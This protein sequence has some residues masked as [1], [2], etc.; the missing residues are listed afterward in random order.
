M[1]KKSFAIIGLGRFGSSVALTL[2]DS[3][4]EVLALDSNEELV[5]KYSD[6]FTHVIAADTTDEN[7]LKSLGMRNFDVVIV[8]IGHDVQASLLTTLL[9]KEIGVE[10]IV[11]KA[12]NLLHGK[13]LE[14]IGANRVV[15]PERD[16][17]QRL[18]HNLISTNVLEYIEL[19]PNFG[20]IEAAVPT[21]LVGQTL[22]QSDLRAKFGIN[23]VALKRKGQIIVSPM[24]TELFELGDILVIIG[25]SLGIQQ[26]EKMRT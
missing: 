21:P 10:H 15:Y 11:A 5:Q 4:Y 14:K 6:K 1:K 13:M 12:D 17:G 18:A 9:L 25:D 7:S 23:V 20:I 3:G 2:L 22:Q 26:F 19:S 8:A 24:P 16:M